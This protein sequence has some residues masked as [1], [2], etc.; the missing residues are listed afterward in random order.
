MNITIFG[1]GAYGTALGETLTDNGHVVSYYDPIKYPE[2][3]LYSVTSSAEVNILATPSN[4]IDKLVLFIPYEKPL[5]CATKG[6]V[7]L[8]KFKDF[9][10]F[11]VLSGAAFAANLIAKKPTVLTATSDIAAQIFANNWLT[12]ERTNDTLGVLL[13]GSLKNIYA[14]GSGF[15]NL[16][17]DMSEFTDYIRI[18]QSEIRLL[19]AANGAD[20]STFNLSCGLNDLI[21]T[22]ASANSRNYRL[23]QQFRQ[24]PNYAVQLETGVARLSDTTEGYN[25]L[26]ALSTSGLQ[27]P[28]EIT[29]LR[30]I[31]STALPP[32][33]EEPKR[34]GRR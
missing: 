7:S 3:S 2:Q 27:I 10:Q 18:A 32:L 6:F 21:L 24:D 17:P 33:P 23:G 1:A 12:I 11:S 5:I 29:L 26:L 30:E 9:R 16:T 20:P 22:C 19:L 28:P 13:C 8:Q 14:I 25:A 34:K 4:A 15:R 31:Y